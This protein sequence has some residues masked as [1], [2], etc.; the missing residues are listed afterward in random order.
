M[1]GTIGG[2]QA[3]LA[4]FFTSLF[5]LSVALV[6]HLLKTVIARDITRRA[7]LSTLA[8]LEQQ[9][10][11]LTTVLDNVR[12]ELE[13]LGGQITTL[14]EQRDTLQVEI[15]D[16]KRQR[17]SFKIAQISP[18]VGDLNA[19]RLAK[20][21]RTMDALLAYLSTHSHASLAQAGRAI[22]RSKTT[23][24]NYV[25]ELTTSGKLQRNGNG[26]EVS[27]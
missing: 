2:G 13:K 22:G 23:V 21:V 19:A 16:L 6:T 17:E 27:R 14:T 24:G 11:N 20:K 26:W 1:S 5:P 4:V 8:E 3:T 10:V 7:V 25:D 15:A 12:H 9:R 18:K